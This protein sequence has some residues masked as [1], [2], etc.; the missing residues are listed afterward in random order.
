MSTSTELSLI[1]ATKNR[2]KQLTNCLQA[3]NNGNFNNFELI[4]VDQSC[5]KKMSHTLKR[6]IKKIKNCRYIYTS[7]EG[8]SKALN[9]A[10]KL[11]T[12]PIIAFTDDDCLPSFNWLKN[13]K[14]TLQNDKKIVAVF[15]K[16]LPYKKNIN[17]G[18]VCPA[19][20]LKNQKRYISKPCKHW[21]NIGFGNNMAWKSS[22]FKKYGGFKE[23]LGPGTRTK[24]AEDAEIALRALINKKTILYE[25]K[26]ILHHNRWL[27]K[28]EHQKL[29]LS[30]LGGEI[31]CYSY[32]GKFDHQ[33]SK[34]VLNENLKYV[35]SDFKN[36][37]NFCHYKTVKE[38]FLKFSKKTYEI[39]KGLTIANYHSTK[40]RFQ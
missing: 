1:I 21:E 30:Y 6:E 40:E 29:K 5:S 23:W 2:Q 20:F 19:V 11:S 15:G 26:I 17:N 22:F 3:L 4:V 13:I 18:L 10:I 38:N 7:N 35:Y 25:P 34:Q 37:F 14:S 9:L 12:T 32:I 24:S 8:K 28:K 39:V 27:T 16:T 36:I 33:L 31:A